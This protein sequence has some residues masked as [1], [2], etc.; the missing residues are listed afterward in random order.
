MASGDFVSSGPLKAGKWNV[1]DLTSLAD[2]A[3]MANGVSLALTTRSRNGLDLASRECGVRGPRLVVE[4]VAGGERVVR[5]RRRPSPRRRRSIRPR[6][7]N[8]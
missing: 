7:G 1:V 8:A 6:S 3:A 4:R 2:Q 5:R